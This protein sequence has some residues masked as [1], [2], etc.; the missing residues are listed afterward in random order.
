VVNAGD[1]MDMDIADEDIDP[2]LQAAI[3]ASRNQQ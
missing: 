2:E 1:Y 3:E